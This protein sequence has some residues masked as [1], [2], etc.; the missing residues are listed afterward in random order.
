MRRSDGLEASGKAENE[1]VT[2]VVPLDCNVGAC[3]YCNVR[4]VA[5]VMVGSVANCVRGTGVGGLETGTGVC[6]NNFK[7]GARSGC[8][9]G[10]P[11]GRDWR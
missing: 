1:R 7:G 3:P 6:D 11:W 2:R 5:V 9:D 10:A 8:G 4:K